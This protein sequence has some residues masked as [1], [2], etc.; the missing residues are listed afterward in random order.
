MDGKN[1]NNELWKEWYGWEKKRHRILSILNI[2][3]RI[4][5]VVL[6]IMALVK[7]KG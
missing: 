4:L 5:I 2:V 7:K 3:A 6:L 1:H